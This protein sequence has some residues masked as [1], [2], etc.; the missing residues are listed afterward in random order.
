VPT[1]RKLYAFPN[2]VF[3]RPTRYVSDLVKLSLIYAYFLM[4][5]R[6]LV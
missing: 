2:V 6:L 3:S 1:I 5:L 4:L